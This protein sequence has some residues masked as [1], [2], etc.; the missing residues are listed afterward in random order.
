MENKNV[1]GAANRRQFLINTGKQALWMA[2]TQTVLMSASRQPAG[3]TGT[4]Y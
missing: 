4:R 3:A 1:S 2:P